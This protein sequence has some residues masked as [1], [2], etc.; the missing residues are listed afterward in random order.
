M[1]VCANQL[2]NYKGEADFYAFHRWDIRWSVR[3]GQGID[4]TVMESI[5]HKIFLKSCIVMVLS[6]VCM[7]KAMLRWNYVLHSQAI[8]IRKSG[9]VPGE[10][11]VEFPKT[12]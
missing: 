11:I 8:S 1:N 10:Q 7:E 4:P 12:N 9:G 2:F 3:L 5:S 6:I